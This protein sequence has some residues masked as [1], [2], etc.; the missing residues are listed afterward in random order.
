MQIINL[1][2]DGEITTKEQAAALV[3][4]EVAEATAFY[5][6]SEEES[7]L[8]I[9]TNIGYATGYLSH[10]QADTL[11]DLFCTEHPIFGREHPTPEEALRLEMELGKS[12]RTEKK[13]E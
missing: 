1:V 3:A 2:T 5:Q 11:M 13:E 9:L 6:I 10:K 12:S 4:E 7:R 8:R